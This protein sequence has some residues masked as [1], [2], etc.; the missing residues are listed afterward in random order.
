MANSKAA[1]QT[2]VR[3]IL[4]TLGEFLVQIVIAGVISALL[5]QALKLDAYQSIVTGV[6]LFVAVETIRLDYRMSRSTEISEKLAAEQHGWGETL[7]ALERLTSTEKEARLLDSKLHQ[8]ADDLRVVARTYP[9]DKTLFV[10]W[11]EDK[12]EALHRHLRHTLENDAYYFDAS[13]LQEENRMYRVFQGKE[14]DYFWATSSCDSIPWYATTG[15]DLFI[16]AI[17]ERLR[18]GNIKHVRRIFTYNSQQELEQLSTKIC[19]YLHARSGY[20]YRIMAWSDYRSIIE[21]FGDRTLVPDFGIYGPYFVWETPSE[22][23]IS[24]QTGYVCVDTAKIA[25][26]TRLFEM[27]WSQALPFDVVDED[28]TTK[29][30]D[31]RLDSFRR[32]MLTIRPV[33]C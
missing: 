19:F 31:L 13:L 11:Y 15:G 28:F 5:Q 23:R 2:N 21:D 9:V 8:I 22:E 27:L 29:Y 33:P 1:R 4:Y 30:G 14:Q 16:R 6:L 10:Q 17:D 3:Q 20:D 32:I 26:Y 12:L 24:S 25:K 18:A 7:T